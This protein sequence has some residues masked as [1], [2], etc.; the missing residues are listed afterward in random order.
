MATSPRVEYALEELV[1]LPHVVVVGGGFAGLATVRK[2]MNRPVR[3]TIINKHNFHTFLPL[4]YQVATAGLEPADV[5][6]PIRT[7]FGH[8]KNVN[9]RHASVKDVD[10]S[11]NVVI[12]DT[13]A[14]IE[15]DHL[16]VAT[17]ATASFFNIPG[18]ARYAMP[19]YTLS[20]ARRLRNRL[21]RALEEAEVASETSEVSLNF[22]VVGG[23]PTGVETAGALSELIDIAIRRDG[24]RLDPAR[25]RIELVDVAPRLLTAFPES[26]SQYA[27]K[28]LEKMD[29]DVELG[30]SVVEVGDRSIVFSDGERFETA[31][32]IWAAG[33]TA[34]GTLADA[35]DGPKGPSGRVLVRADLRLVESEKVWCV[36][37]AAA[38][39]GVENG[40]YPQLAPVAIQSGRHC[41]TQILRV[42]AGEPTLPFRYHNKGIMATIGRRAAVAKLPHGAV[43]RGTIGWFAWLG[44]HLWYLVGFRN[45]LRVMINWMW[46]Y[47]DWP[48]GPRLIVADAETAE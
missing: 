33:V 27:R 47:F 25:V 31:A 44:L 39:P 35:L 13:G 23:G 20:N 16:V 1:T 29:V 7:V 17:G 8:A 42:L 2:L 28:V 45:R 34:S 22:V 4:L 11:R 36:G 3:V 26:A 40:F 32:V 24:L 21:L 38:I 43:V 30:R 14:E 12:L 41:A 48:S 37:D 19:L 15:Y 6:Y 10:Q 9:V 5:A 18:A 46:R